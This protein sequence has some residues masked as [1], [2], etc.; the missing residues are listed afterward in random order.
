LS[1]FGG[2]VANARW[3]FWKL[4]KDYYGESEEDH[5]SVKRGIEYYNETH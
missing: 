3:K 4:L 5:L 2:G 1:Y